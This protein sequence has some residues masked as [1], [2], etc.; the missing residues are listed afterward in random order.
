MTRLNPL[1]AGWLF[2]AFGFATRQTDVLKKTG[3]LITIMSDS[4]GDN[5][6]GKNY[7]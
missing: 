4:D 1:H 7:F 6:S 3:L 2:Q 5:I